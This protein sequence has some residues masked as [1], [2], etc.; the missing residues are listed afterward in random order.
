M[1]K[2]WDYLVESD[3]KLR[4][5]ERSYQT[6]R[7]PE[8]LIAWLR[9][10]IQTHGEHKF[11]VVATRDD[12]E[13]FYIGWARSAKGSPGWIIKHRSTEGHR[14][15]VGSWPVSKSKRTSVKSM[16]NSDRALL[17]AVE[18]FISMAEGS[19]ISHIVYQ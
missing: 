10:G 8:A 1:N 17:Y 6:K 13:S 18:A 7:T 15:T 3:A 11:F 4:Q 5:L 9:F 12:G 19:T 14:S 2:P 16:R